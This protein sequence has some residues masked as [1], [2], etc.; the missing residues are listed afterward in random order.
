MLRSLIFLLLPFL[1]LACDK[2]ED[3]KTAT[4]NV[5][6]DAEY[7]GERLEL[8]KAY[9]YG[10]F[11][12]QFTIFNLYVSDMTL[13]KSDGTSVPVQEVEFLNFNNSPTNQTPTVRFA[14]PDMPLEDYSAVRLGIGV[15]A[16]L[17]AKKPADFASGHPLS[18]EE[19]Y[20][21]GWES[22]IFTQIQGFADVD[23]D[24]QPDLTMFYHTGSDQVYQELTLPLPTR[25]AAG[26][27]ELAF[28]ID[29]K[30]LFTQ[31]DG[32]LYDIVA[33]PTTA[34]DPSNLAVGQFIMNNYQKAITVTQ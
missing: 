29:L 28:T 17:N 19:F 2:D 25:N 3:V 34:H 24:G 26:S 30:Q 33:N 32:L 6:F 31:A 18:R 20:W 9:D 22:Y 16:D 21:P 11:P 13:L 8:Q 15:K 4:L 23:N 1:F 10:G 5:S 7:D 12:V 14:Y 27:W